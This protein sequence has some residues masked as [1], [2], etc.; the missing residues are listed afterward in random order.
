ME[1]FVEA[2]KLIFD[3]EGIRRNS[4][5]LHRITGYYCPGCGGQRAFVLLLQGH[6][7]LSLI[8]N[9]AVIYILIAIV[10]NCIKLFICKKISGR[11]Y[12]FSL[13]WVVG[14]VVIVLIS[15]TAKNILVSKGV[16]PLNLHLED[17]WIY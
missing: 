3:P 13:A 4:C 1:R 11:K 5:G 14:L 10:I 7:L 12:T 2:I 8:Y 9:P 17:L 6:P 15:T 16:D